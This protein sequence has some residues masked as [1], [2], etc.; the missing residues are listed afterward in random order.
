[1]TARTTDSTLTYAELIAL[2]LNNMQK[3]K[4]NFRQLTRLHWSEWNYFNNYLRE[5]RENFLRYLRELAF[6]NYVLEI[7]RSLQLS[8]RLPATPAAEPD[9]SPEPTAGNQ[10]WEPSPS[11]PRLKL[12]TEPGSPI[13]CA[14]SQ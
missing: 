6:A 9:W 2:T 1:M 13:G 14:H 11:P 10:L 12:G 4:D 7:E 8:L 3:R 5:L